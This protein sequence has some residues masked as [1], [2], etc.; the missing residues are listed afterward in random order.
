ML[1]IGLVVDST[2]AEGEKDEDVCRDEG[3]LRRSRGSGT[4]EIGA[5]ESGDREHGD[6]RSQRYPGSR[7]RNIR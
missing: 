3:V 7:L 6:D 4:D 2:Q 1:L 5:H